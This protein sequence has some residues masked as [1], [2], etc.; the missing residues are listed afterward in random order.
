VVVVNRSNQITIPTSVD[1][2]LTGASA[3]EGVDY[4]DGPITIEFAAD[5][6]SK[7]VPIEILGDNSAEPDETIDL[8]FANFSDNGQAGT[9]LPTTTFMLLNDDSGTYYVSSSTGNDNNDGLSISTPWQTIGRVNYHRFVDGDTLCFNRGDTFGDASLRLFNISNNFTIRDY[10]TGD[11]PWFDGNA[12]HPDNPIELRPDTQV[13]N[14][15][16][17]NIDIS[18]Q[19]WAPTKSPNISIRNVNGL[20]IDSIFGDGHRGW[21]GSTDAKKAIDVVGPCSGLIEIKNC[22]FVNWGPLDL[23][24]GPIDYIAVKITEVTDPDAEVLI[25][26]NIIH[27]ITSDAVHVVSSTAPTC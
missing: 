18:G 22:T 9:S 12:K 8:S 7:T 2:I 4:D 24:S 15:T 17:M 25:H 6:I 27:D 5:E 19:G 26:D 20:L 10:G 13:D 14:L 21:D 11:L 3:T 23:L 16:I 1:V